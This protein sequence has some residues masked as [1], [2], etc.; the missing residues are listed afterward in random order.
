MKNIKLILVIIASLYLNSCEKVVDIDLDTASPKLVIEASIIWQKGT[1]GSLQKIKLTTTSNF[2]T[3]TTPIVS[4]ATVFIT[5]SDNKIFDFIE[6]PN[7]GEYICSN[8]ET[9]LNQNYTLTVINN[10]QNYTA[11]ETLKPVANIEEIIQNNEGGLTGKEIQVKAIYTDPANTENYYLYKYR[12]PNQIKPDYYADEDTFFQGNPFFSVSFN[13]DLK[14]G[15]QIEITHFGISKK[16]YNYMT[17]LLGVSGNTGGGPFQ[18]P[19]ATVRGNIIN[20]TNPDN[21]PF[22]YFNLSETDSRTYTI[23]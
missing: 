15:N 5:N 9:V 21:F 17:I 7:T 12:Y 11:T 4:G 23:Q 18:A 14:I 1:T 13:D 22:G 10:G 3:N 8:F 2:Y 16:Y 20:N 19:P 6:K